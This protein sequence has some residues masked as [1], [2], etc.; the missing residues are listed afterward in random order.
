MLITASHRGHAYVCHQRGE[1]L[2]GHNSLPSP[3]RDRPIEESLLLFEVGFW[4]GTWGGWVGMLQVRW[5]SAEW[6]SELSVL[7]GNA[8]R[9]ICGGRGHS[10]DEACDG[11]WQNGPCGLSSQVYTTPPYRRYLVG[12]SFEWDSG[13]WGRAEWSWIAAHSL[14]V[15]CRCI[16]PTYDYTHCLCDSIE[17]I[18]HSLCTKEFQAR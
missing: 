11:G 6:Q 7:L 10:S 4:K 9:Q 5:F 12:V 3:W 2:K 13:T 8:Q 17:H 14:S 18:T 15:L 1:E 16:Y